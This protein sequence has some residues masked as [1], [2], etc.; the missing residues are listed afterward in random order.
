MGAKSFDS[1]ESGIITRSSDESLHAR[2][3]LF[4]MS[5]SYPATDTE[6]E[7]SAGLFLRASLLARFL[8]VYEIYKR[9]VS[10]PGAVFDIG[11]W[12][13]QTAVL[14][15]NFR[16]I[17]EPLNLDRRIFAFDTFLG[18]Q[19]FTDQDRA[20]E[21][22][23]NGTYSVGEDYPELLSRILELHEKSNALGHYRGKHLV[24]SGDIRETLPELLDE[25]PELFVSL[26][27]IDLNSVEPT[28]AV[29]ET[30][31]ERIIPNGVVAFWQL[32][33][34]KIPGD[35]MAYVKAVL[36]LRSHR[37]ERSEIYPGL[38]FITKVC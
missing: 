1:H 10:L 9:I 22:H 32:T 4:E 36:K 15:E 5:K 25:H 23:R 16:A 31:W 13:G 26:A 34:P 14:L 24:V 7:R 38:C 37:I 6:R 20:T 8:A 2:I 35:G 18:Y 12:R 28:E 3:E 21:L 27:F 11:T 19:G 33:Q 17:L 30:L 29:L